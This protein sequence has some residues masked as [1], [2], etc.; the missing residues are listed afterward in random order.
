MLMSHYSDKMFWGE[1]GIVFSKYV[2]I[3][4]LNPLKW[5]LRPCVWQ[6]P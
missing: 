6:E 2:Q 5:T 4:N 1:H 3:A